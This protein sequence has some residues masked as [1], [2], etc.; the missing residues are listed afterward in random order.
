[1]TAG[2]NSVISKAGAGRSVSFIL[3]SNLDLDGIHLGEIV[4]SHP[5]PITDKKSFEFLLRKRWKIVRQS[6]FSFFHFYIPV[7][8]LRLTL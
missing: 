4:H 8:L 7:Q 1:M 3:I 2:T 5:Y 6:F